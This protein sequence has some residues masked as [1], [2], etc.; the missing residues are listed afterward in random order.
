MAQSRDNAEEWLRLVEEGK[1]PARRH[2]LKIAGSPI[3]KLPRGMSVEF[4]LDATGCTELTE[5]PDNLSVPVLVLRGCNRLPALPEGLRCDY[6]DVQD[7]GALAHWPAS[8]QVTIGTVNARR[9]RSLT[10]LPPTLGPISSLNLE[11]CERISTIPSGIQVR[12]WIDVGGTAICSLPESLSGVALRWRGVAVNAQIA[13]FPETLKVT[14]VVAE[15]NAELRRVMIERIG[16]DR[17]VREANA[18]IVD[19]DQDAGGPRELLRVKLEGDE[20]LVCVS[21]RCPS[22]GRHYLI[23]VPPSMKTCHQAVAWTAGFDNPEDYHP[24]LET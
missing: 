24:I 7:C 15:R 19:Q 9:C 8:V 10:A 21:V 2:T 23:R 14:D 22:T 16:F 17:F 18:K 4:K 1:V 6:L 12:S 3:R 11:G 13:F 5:L 20:D